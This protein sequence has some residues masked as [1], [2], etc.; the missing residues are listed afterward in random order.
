MAGLFPA[1]SVLGEFLEL[2][3]NLNFI[4]RMEA[5]PSRAAPE[6]SRDAPSQL[7]NQFQRKLEQTGIANFLRL[8]KRRIR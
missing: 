7:K 8:A 2:S 5:R 3:L 6:N 4:R 1:V